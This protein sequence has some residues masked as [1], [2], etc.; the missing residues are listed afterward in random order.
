MSRLHEVRAKAK[1]LLAIGPSEKWELYSTFPKAADGKDRSFVLQLRTAH[2]VG[3]AL[4]MAAA[5]IELP[6]AA[7]QWLELK[8]GKSVVEHKS[9]LEE[10]GLY[11]RA[12][13]YVLGEE[14]AVAELKREA[15][16]V[17]IFEAAWNGT[18]SDVQLVCSWAP[19]KVNMVDTPYGKSALHWAAKHNHSQVAQVLLAAKAD[20]SAKNK[21][22]VTPLHL[23]ATYSQSEVAEILIAAGADMD[24][25]N[26]AC[27]TPLAEAKKLDKFGMAQLLEDRDR[28]RREALA[29][30]YAKECE[31]EKE[32]EEFQYDNPQLIY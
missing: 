11:D 29:R 15:D 9:T 21:L 32:N 12:E 8:V 1:R 14:R 4:E 19:E 25:E 23:A 27:N 17:N 20:P 5:K 31:Q 30:S 22:G 2:T 24:A 28:E 6:A 3:E 18:L 26:I 7:A 10:A 16:K 13:F